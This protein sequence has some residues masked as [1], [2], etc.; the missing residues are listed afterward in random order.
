MNNR[1]LLSCAAVMLLLSSVSLPA[2]DADYASILKER[3]AVLTRIV[4]DLEA[5]Y[6]TGGGS[7]QA[8]LTAQLAL[9]SFRRD[10]AQTTNQKIEQQEEI[11]G[12]QE[13]RLARL[14]AGPISDP[15]DVLRATDALLEAKQVL[16]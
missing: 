6:R 12:L 16:E 1:C 10:T 15:L 2:A 8:V 9:Y 3:D 7:E 14:K 13:S 4:S 11:I 5:R